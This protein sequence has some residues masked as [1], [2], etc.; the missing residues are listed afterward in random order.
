[1][2]RYSHAV[3]T[4]TQDCSCP[5]RCHYLHD[6]L[7]NSK[8]F[9]P[10]RL[11]ELPYPDADR[12]I[13]Q[14]ND[15]RRAASQEFYTNTVNALNAAERSAVEKIPNLEDIKG[16]VKKGASPS[17]EQGPAKPIRGQKQ[18]PLEIA[19]PTKGLADDKDDNGQKKGEEDKSKTAPGSPKKMK[20]GEKWDMAT[21]KEA[22]PKAGKEEEAKGTEEDHEV[23][24]ELNGILKKGPSTFNA[25]APVP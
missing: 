24:V 16:A 7:P 2:S 3:C 8:P 4:A 15:S 6:L 20:G 21:G 17:R 5:S 23:E 25:P 19:V 18:A 22:P 14:Q 1:M 13:K 11:T 9:L 10:H 12:L